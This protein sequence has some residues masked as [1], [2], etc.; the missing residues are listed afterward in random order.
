MQ[1]KHAWKGI[2]GYIGDLMLFLFGRYQSR[3]MKH[4][5]ASFEC[6]GYVW[7]VAYVAFYHVYVLRDYFGWGVAQIVQ[8]DDFVSE[9]CQFA[10]QVPSYK[11]IPAGYQYSH[12]NPKAR[13]LIR[14]ISKK[15][16][17]YFSEYFVSLY[18]G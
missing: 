2:N 1:D 9:L 17:C 14:L 5:F 12:A 18:A 4:R 8:N 7:F 16:G 15:Q 13:K 10:A 11:A 3:E 6:S